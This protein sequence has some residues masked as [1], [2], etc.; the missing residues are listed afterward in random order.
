MTF[1]KIQFD[2]EYEDTPVTRRTIANYFFNDL[3]GLETVQGYS[4]QYDV[5]VITFPKDDELITD[6]LFVGLHGAILRGETLEDAISVT[7]MYWPVICECVERFNPGLYQLYEYDQIIRH[8][9]RGL[10][11]DD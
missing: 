3:V 10:L 8:R 7:D 9:P 2:K 6:L 11:F 5:Y 1:R 4:S